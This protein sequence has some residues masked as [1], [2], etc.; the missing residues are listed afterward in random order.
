MRC[1][2]PINYWSILYTPTRVEKLAQR[3]GV[4]K[5]EDLVLFGNYEIPSS[6]FQY[7]DIIFELFEN[8]SVGRRSIS[9]TRLCYVHVLF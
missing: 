9:G 4:R 1:G 6:T 5:V 3:V 2:C 7:S 8:W